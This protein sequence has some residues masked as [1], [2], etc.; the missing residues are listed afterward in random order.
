MTFWE[1]YTALCRERG[2]KPTKIGEHVKVEGQPI[3]KSSVSTWRYGAVPRAITR[4]ALADFFKVKPDYLTNDKEEETEPKP[5]KDCSNCPC[6][7]K[8]P[9]SLSPQEQQIIQMFREITEVEKM[10][11][12]KTIFDIWEHDQ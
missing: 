10:R 12:I 6:K 9:G 8:C 7:D 5:T 11:I 4:K 3:S 1:K 2:I